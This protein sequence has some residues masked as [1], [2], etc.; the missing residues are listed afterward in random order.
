LGKA[1]LVAAAVAKGCNV[2]ETDQ[3]LRSGLDYAARLG[4]VDIVRVLFEAPMFNLS[5]KTDGLLFTMPPT[6]GT[7]TWF[8]CW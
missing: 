3:N 7:L 5:A 2:N 1:D 6:N 4:H 8:G